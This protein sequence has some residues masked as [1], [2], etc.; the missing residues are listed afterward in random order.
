MIVPAAALAAFLA[1]TAAAAEAPLAKASGKV[2]KSQS[3]IAPSSGGPVFREGRL[4]IAGKRGDEDYKATPR[5]KVTLDGKPAKFPKAAVAGALVLKALYDPATRELAS[6]DLK[7]GPVLGEI[8]NTD[9]LTGALSVRSADKSLRE[10]VVPE[11]A[12]IRREADGKA[13]AIPFEALEVG[14]AVEVFSADGKTAV[15]IHAR[16]AR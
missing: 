1:L 9:I 10:F 13:E 16:A 3:K 5:T 12:K 4:T 14:D 11:N 2:L 6:L 15:E 8:A 7:S